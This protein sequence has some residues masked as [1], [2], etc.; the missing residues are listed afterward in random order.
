[1]YICDVT[2]WDFRAERMQTHRSFISCCILELPKRDYGNQC[3]KS[4][5]VVVEEEAC[6]D[7]SER[8]V[9]VLWSDCG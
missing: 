4:P 6:L 3:T 1:M 2:S 8:L 9:N 7:A 5:V